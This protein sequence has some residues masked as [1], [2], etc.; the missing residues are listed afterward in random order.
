MDSLSTIKFEI[1]EILEQNKHRMVSSALIPVH[2][3]TSEPLP[4]TY[5]TEPRTTTTE[6]GTEIE[7]TEEEEIFE[8]EG[9]P[10]RIL[11]LGAL[12]G[13]FCSLLTRKL[14][15]QK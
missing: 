13:I 4:T 1:P 9:F 7:T 12:I 11:Y 15:N 2:K 5:P 10:L 6:T 8:I 3:D 14:N